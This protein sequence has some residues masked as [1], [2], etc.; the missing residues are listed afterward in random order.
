MTERGDWSDWRARRPE[1]PGLHLDSAAAGRS[2]T[3]VLDAVHAHALR[4]AREGAYVAEAGAADEVAALRGDVAGLLGRTADDVAFVES[5]TAAMHALLRAWPVGDGDTL[6]VAPSEWGPNLQAFGHHRFRLVDLPVDAGGHLDL[7]AFEAL[8]HRDPPTV[9]HLTQ[10]SAHR[11]LVQP[12]AEAAALCR[13]AG[14]PLWVDAAQAIGHVDTAVDADVVAATG[15][16]WLAG[17][18]GVG[19][20]AVAPRMLDR[21]AVPEPVLQP[22]R[23]VAHRLESHE[24]HV[25]GRVGLATAVREHLADG[26]TRVRERLA[27]VGR[28]TREVLAGLPGWEVVGA[29]DEPCAVTALRPTDGQD[30]VAVRG[31]L[32]A[33]HGILTTAGLPPR[34]P[35]EMTSALLRVSPHVDCTEADLTRLRDALA[36]A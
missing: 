20:L 9:V 2:S 25:A 31:R 6:A 35:R 8:L 36:H 19:L 26:P 23:P 10:V 13:A 14:V 27:E 29:A 16:K 28:R 17:P 15:R 4:E 7:A 33:G 1:F 5:A 18:R 11:G 21:L 24:A 12:V 34:A 22:G 32:L 30:V 3:A